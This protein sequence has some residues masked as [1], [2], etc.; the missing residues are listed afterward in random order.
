MEQIDLYPT[1]ASLAGTSV[2]AHCQGEDLTQVLADPRRSVREAAYTTK[3]GGHLVRTAEYAYIEHPG[4]EAELYDMRVD[5]QQF[6][7]LAE[8]S[9]H[10]ETRARLARM[11]AAKLATIR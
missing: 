1:L 7:N 11:L 2:P 10:A 6:T 5:P 9:E 8:L 3:G 4:G